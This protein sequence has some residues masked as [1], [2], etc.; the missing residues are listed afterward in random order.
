M[1]ALGKLIRGISGWKIG[2]HPPTMKKYVLIAAPHTTNWD[3]VH[4]QSIGYSLGMKV[5]WMGKHTLFRP[6][7]GPIMRALGGVPVVRHER[8]N[9][10]DQMADMFAERGEFILAIPPEGTRGKA[11]Y[12]R[13]G[14]YHIARAANVP[15]V[16]G[17]LDY[18]N[19]TG[20][21]GPP[22][23]PTG[24]VKADMDVL[25]A[26]YAPF[27]GKYHDNFGPIRLKEEG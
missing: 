27:R 1:K 5:S 22:L 17:Y 6:P 20:G 21:F 10:V 4:M 18:P 11:E 14:F 12:W 13:S 26:F 8:R 3:L 16:P 24:N 25:R 2:D 15:I 7:F 23:M 19:K 9:M